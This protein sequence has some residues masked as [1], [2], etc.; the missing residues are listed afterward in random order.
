MDRSPEATAATLLDRGGTTGY[1][2]RY[3]PGTVHDGTWST[4]Y[5]TRQGDYFLNGWGKVCGTTVLL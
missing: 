1:L 2:Y 5:L 4:F 3:L